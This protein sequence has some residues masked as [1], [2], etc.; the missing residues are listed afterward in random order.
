MKQLFLTVQS[1]KLALKEPESELRIVTPPRHEADHHEREPSHLDAICVEEFIVKPPTSS[2]IPSAPDS[3]RRRRTLR[4]SRRFANQYQLSNDNGI[5]TLKKRVLSF[6][7][8]LLLGVHEKT[9]Q[10]P[11]N[12]N[13]NPSLL[14]LPA[15][16]RLRIYR[17]LLLRAARYPI[18]RGSHDFHIQ[19]GDWRME[20]C[21]GELWPEILATCRLIHR[22][23]TPI[24]YGE[25]MF[26]R[27]FS[28]PS[29]RL[30]SSIPLPRS[31]TSKLSKESISYISAIW[32]AEKPDMWLDYQKRAKS[33][34]RFP[35]LTTD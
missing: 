1:D 3:R 20:R 17:H 11:G 22:E 10:Q 24:L 27:V 4:S 21:A 29:K 32:L 31:L 6:E 8:V 35:R 33:L 9:I 14:R 30:F 23:G 25:N 26:E 28:W 18:F 34:S 2:A 19:I 7:K 12:F 13:N 16:L 15:E 5:L